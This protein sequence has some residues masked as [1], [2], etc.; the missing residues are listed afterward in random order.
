[1]VIARPDGSAQS[2]ATSNSQIQLHHRGFAADGPINSVECPSKFEV[3]LNV[4]LGK[5]P[6]TF[7]ATDLGK[8]SL[9]WADGTAEPSIDKCSEWKGRRVKVW[10]APTPGKE[11]AGEITDLFFF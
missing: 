9:T 8:I 2:E 10:F 11:Y 6:V 5:G 1:M 7:H 3:F 4:N